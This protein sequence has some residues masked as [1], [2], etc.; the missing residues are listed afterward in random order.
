MPADWLSFIINMKSINTQSKSID[1][2][3]NIWGIASYD[4]SKMLAGDK[5]D[6]NVT[7]DFSHA[8]SVA[9]A[10]AKSAGHSLHHPSQ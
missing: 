2:Y 10:M 5:K 1:I 6:R 9:I 8:S 3:G 7:D 4:M